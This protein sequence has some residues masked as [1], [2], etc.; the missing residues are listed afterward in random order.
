MYGKKRSFKMTRLEK[1]ASKGDTTI[2]VAK[3]LDLVKGD[4]IALAAT[5]FI[6]DTGE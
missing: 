1:A 6:Y 3:N 2:N 4:K 5:S